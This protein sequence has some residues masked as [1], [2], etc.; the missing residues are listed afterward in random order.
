MLIAGLAA[1]LRVKHLLSILQALGW[2]PIT[3]EQTN[4]QIKPQQ[5]D[6]VN[7]QCTGI[8]SWISLPRKTNLLVLLEVFAIS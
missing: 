4:K 8:H 2:A 7:T 3:T 5:R 1:W 6:G